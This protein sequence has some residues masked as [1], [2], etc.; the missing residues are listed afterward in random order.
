MEC[1]ALIAAAKFRD[2]K[3]GHYLEV[4]DDVSSNEWDSRNSDNEMPFKVK[5]FWL[6]VEACLE[7]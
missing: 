6:S 7:L 5:V 3:F 2:V 1:S 4:S